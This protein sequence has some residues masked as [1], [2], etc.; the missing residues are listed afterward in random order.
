MRTEG[1]GAAVMVR[2]FAVPSDLGR[3]PRRRRKSLVDRG[4]AEF[5]AWKQF[6]EVIQKRTP[7]TQRQRGVRAALVGVAIPQDMC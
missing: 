1:P 3:S 5:D 7:R 6:V 4:G 2:P